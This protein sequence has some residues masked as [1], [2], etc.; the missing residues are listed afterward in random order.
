MVPGVIAAFKKSG[1]DLL[2]ES[3]AGRPAGFPDNEYAEKGARIVGSRAQVFAESEILLQVRAPGANPEAGAADAAMMKPGQT[4]I[5]FTEA[6]TAFDSVR[7]LA[8]R[9]VSLFS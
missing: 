2:V 4:V 1:V 8:E 7:M 3:G 5:G 6:L 9:Q